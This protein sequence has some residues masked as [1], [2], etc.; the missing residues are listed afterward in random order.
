VIEIKIKI[1]KLLEYKLKEASSKLVKNLN[2]A[3]KDS[4]YLIHGTAV[5]GIQ[6]GQ[7]TGRT[8][9]RGNVAHTAS[10]PGEYP[11]SDTGRLAS[12]MR[13]NLSALE[14]NIGSD[15]NYAAYLEDGTKRIKPRP[16]LEP[17]FKANE[18]TISL[19]ID[20]AVNSMFD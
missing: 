7:K 12:S 18:E 14:A 3:I 16:Y 20:E 8:Y 17:S 2:K 1:D 5:K 13:V 19:L 4:A 10:S 6:R 9:L 15:V 11:A